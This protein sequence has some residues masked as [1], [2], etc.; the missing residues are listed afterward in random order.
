MGINAFF[1]FLS[2]PKIKKP[3]LLGRFHYWLPATQVTR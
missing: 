3:T 1:I 2:F